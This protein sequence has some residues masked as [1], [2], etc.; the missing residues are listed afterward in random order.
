MSAANAAICAQD[1][2]RR[3]MVRMSGVENVDAPVRTYRERN[4]ID[5]RTIKPN[6]PCCGIAF[7]VAW[8]ARQNRDLELPS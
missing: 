7:F 2:S 3:H 5:R 4:R 1:Q 8:G 6:A